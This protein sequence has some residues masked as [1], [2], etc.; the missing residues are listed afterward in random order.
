LIA[1]VAISV[2]D[3]KRSGE[4]YDALLTPIGWRRHIEDG[5]KIGWGRARPTFIVTTKGMPQP[6]FGQIC[7]GAIGIAAIKAAWEAVDKQGLGVTGELGGKP[8]YSSGAYSAFVTD[9]DGY[10]IELTVA[11]Q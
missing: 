5:Q 1:N 4:F 7:L 9:P 11:P 6:G 8:R 3:L 2:T 10:E